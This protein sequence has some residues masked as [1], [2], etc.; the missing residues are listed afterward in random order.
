MSRVVKVTLSPQSIDNALKVVKGYKKWIKQ[1]V[2]ELIDKLLE[3]GEDYAI[4]EVGHVDTGATLSSIKG[5]RKG[6]K[7]V[8]VAGGNAIWLEFGTGVKY[9]GSVGSSPHPKGKEL[10]MTI[11]TYGK[12][13]G[14][15]P[16]GWWYQKDGEEEWKH[17]YGIKANMFMY[18]TARELE[19]IAPKLAREVFGDD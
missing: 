19:K 18:R 3:V 8:I 10:D 16:Q 13:H 12:G 11:G 4:N 6:N 9:N 15:E 14:A 2:N 1:K 17:T 7:G 5:Y